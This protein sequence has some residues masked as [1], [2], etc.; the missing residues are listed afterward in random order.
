MTARRPP[1][2]IRPL[3]GLAFIAAAVLA[4]GCG[5]DGSANSAPPTG[6]PGDPDA[7]PVLPVDAEPGTCAEPILTQM[8]VGGQ[9]PEDADPIATVILGD[10][11]IMSAA[12]S[13]SNRGTLSFDW[14]LGGLADTAD[15]G[16]D[17]EGLTI[18]PTEP[19]D[20]P[21]TLTLSDDVG[22]DDPITVNLRVLSW[23]PVAQELDVRDV[24][25]GAGRIWI[26]SNDGPRFVDL[27]NLG[28]G[29]QDL[30][31]AADGDEIPAD[32]EAVFFDNDDGLVW[33]GRRGQDDGAYRLDLAAFEIATFAFPSPSI[34]QTAVR[35][36]TTQGNG[37]MFATQDGVTIAADNQT[38]AD[39]IVLDDRDAVGDNDAGGWAGSTDLIR[40]S[41]EQTFTPFGGGDNR[42]LAIAGDDDLLWVGGDDKG[43]ARLNADDSVDVFRTAQGLPSNRVRGLAVDGDHDVWAATQAG[44]ARYKRDRDVWVPMGEESGLGPIT[45]LVSAATGVEGGRTVVVV[46]GTE[47]LAVLGP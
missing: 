44:A 33:F 46:G 10:T 25:V 2:R 5:F 22:S 39:P 47:G 15:P 43:A 41:D 40:L 19:G 38:F 9:S 13:C 45:D 29:A 28:A 23:V 37:V 34:G 42:I 8:L 3:S 18:Y 11:I 1:R 31:A 16:T 6:Q 4:T 21:I 26:A 27:S 35:D 36:I 20:F 30:N 7:S 12:G 24:A 14:Q 32:L 17:G